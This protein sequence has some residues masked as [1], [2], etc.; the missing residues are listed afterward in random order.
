MTEKRTYP[1]DLVIFDCDGV[2]VDSEILGVQIE[3][4]LLRQHGYD[5]DV[6]TMSARFSGMTW[7]DI[8]RTVEAESGLPL[9]ASLLGKAEAIMDERLPVEVLA[10]EGTAAVLAAL[11][12]RHC[13][14]SNTKQSRLNAM[15]RK[16]GLHSFFAPHIYSAKDLGDDRG[17]PE[18][19][20]FLYGAEQM[21]VAPD[22]TV[23][24][25]DS[26]HGVQAARAAGMR[27]IGFVGG[28][29]SY[30]LHA[31]KLVEAGAHAIIQTMPELLARLD[32]MADVSP[33]SHRTSGQ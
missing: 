16:V 9:M 18:P 26:V 27:V 20:V 30:P 28:S 2:L 8:L 17:K 32:D 3:V 4:E 21:G 31:E 1:I 10:I 7:K 25:E 14:C 11:P 12:Y 23:V 15:L 6:G 24:V 29:H 13:V 19:D 22:F 33:S 5:I